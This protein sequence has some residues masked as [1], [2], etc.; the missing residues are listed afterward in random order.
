[1]VGSSGRWF[2]KEEV[3]VVLSALVKRGGGRNY[4]LFKHVH[5]RKKLS[6]AQ[7]NEM[8]WERHTEIVMGFG[9]RPE[10]LRDQSC[11][12]W[13]C[14]WRIWCTPVRTSTARVVRIEY[15]CA[16]R[17]PWLWFNLSPLLFRFILSWFEFCIFDLSNCWLW[18][19]HHIGFLTLCGGGWWRVLKNWCK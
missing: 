7:N 19:V 15:C 14:C 16:N 6:V 8:W 3:D 18:F 5:T 12:V 2:D 11:L 9:V 13:I 4:G 1:M 17:L 10:N